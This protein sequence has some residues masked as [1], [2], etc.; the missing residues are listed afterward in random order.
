M[1][2]ATIQFAR[3]KILFSQNKTNFLRKILLKYSNK[4]TENYQNT[5]IFKNEPKIGFAAKEK[6]R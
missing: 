6:L 2:R 3:V 5:V 4:F 1:T